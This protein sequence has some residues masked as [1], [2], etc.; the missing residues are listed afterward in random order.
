M[1]TF[2]A[3]SHHS[4]FCFFSLVI[5]F[6]SVVC[7]SA[8]SQTFSVLHSFPAYTG[9]GEHPYAS[10]LRDS[11]GN[12]YG[13]TI[14][15]GA[16][17][18]GTVYEVGKTGVESVLY[19]FPAY[20][21]DGS[22]PFSTLVRDSAGNLYGTTY[23][24]G[25]SG[26]G[27]VF[28]LTPSGAETILYSFTGG[29]DGAMP[30]GGLLRDSK[31]NLYGTTSDGGSTLC[32][33]SSGCG[34]I[35]EITSS[36]QEKVLYTFCLAAGCPDGSSPSDELIFD[37]KHNLYGATLGGGYGAGVVFQLA[38][39]GKDAGTETV[40]YTLS[41]TQ[42]GEFPNGVIRDSEGNFYGTTN[43]GPLNDCGGVFQLNSAGSAS[44]LFGFQGFQNGCN[45]FGG[46]LL[47][48]QGNLY[49][50]TSSG[51]TGSG[52]TVFELSPSGTFT[53]LRNLSQ[54]DGISPYAALI[55]DPKGNLYGTNGAGGVNG[56]GTVFELVP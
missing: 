49:G 31:G 29:T 22:N 2:W 27:T 26:L 37:K 54:A 47:D 6:S 39:K 56:S 24:G 8:H 10:L 1:R 25:A 43:A 13:T 7:I 11:K 19:S 34:T 46:L 55:R 14:F 50:T 35:F 36:G 44:L 5:L 9:D 23:S 32:G 30:H 51:G 41:S 38:T 16:N 20:D 40:L 45:P 12:L 15:G 33:M 21:G 48:G 28:K 4:C 18:S 3:A 53:I 52:G 42:I 17:G